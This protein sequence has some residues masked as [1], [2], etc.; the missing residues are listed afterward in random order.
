MAVP[1]LPAYGGYDNHWLKAVRRQQNAF[2]ALSIPAPPVSAARL[3][4]AGSGDELQTA[5]AV[6]GTASACSASTRDSLVA[7]ALSIGRQHG[8]PTFQNK[9]TPMPS[10]PR[11]KAEKQVNKQALATISAQLDPVNIKLDPSTPKQHQESSRNQSGSPT[12]HSITF[13]DENKLAAPVSLHDVTKQQL[14]SFCRTVHHSPSSSR[15]QSASGE[16]ADLIGKSIQAPETPHV[17]CY[18]S[19]RYLLLEEPVFADDAAGFLGPLQTAAAE[20]VKSPNAPHLTTSKVRSQTDE[21]MECML[22]VCGSCVDTSS[23]SRMPAASGSCNVVEATAVVSSAG[24]P[25]LS[26]LSSLP[27]GSICM[28]HR[29]IHACC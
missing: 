27:A 14:L 1:C 6:A 16:A 5:R 25:V 10:M 23:S 3:L 8:L 26:V 9:H 17:H 2:A 12:I 28:S 11:S 7:Q 29:Y 4:P 18:G 13:V 20:P 15:Q 24:I 21:A 22:C 19:Q